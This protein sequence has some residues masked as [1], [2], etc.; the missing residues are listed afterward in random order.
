MYNRY[1]RGQSETTPL[2]GCFQLDEQNDSLQISYSVSVIYPSGEW[3]ILLTVSS[4]S[5]Y[6]VEAA[7]H[8][9]WG[10]RSSS[11]VR[12][13][14]LQALTLLGRARFMARCLRRLFLGE[15]RQGSRHF[16]SRQA[17]LGYGSLTGPTFKK[18]LCHTCSLFG[19][20]DKE[21]KYADCLWRQ[22]LLSRGCQ[23]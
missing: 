8:G 10:R 23:T 20:R 5:G 15:C 21:R 22:R 17:C 7:W 6:S 14:S 13:P 19:A 1:T 3:V 9:C 18:A 12:E 11:S 16:W 2:V 4:G